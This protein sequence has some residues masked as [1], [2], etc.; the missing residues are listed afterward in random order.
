MA[1]SPT[2][3]QLEDAASSGGE[4]GVPMLGVRQD[5]DATPVSASGDW[6]PFVFDEVGRLK[7][8]TA[9]SSIVAT[10]GTVTTS[11]STVVCDV[12]RASNV[13]FYCT[14]TFAGV[15]CTFEGSLDG[16]TSWFTVQAVRS[17][18]NTIETTTGVL[19]AAPAYAWE[20]SVNGLTTFR[21]RATAWT[22]G[23]QNWRI[24][25]GSYATEPIPAAQISG[26]QPVSGTVTV[27]LPTGTTY[28]VVTTASTN[29]ASVKASA[30]SLYEMTISNPTATAAY[31]KLYNKASAP[32][33]GTD[34]PVM[35]VAIPAT[36]VGVG[37]KTFNFGAVGKRFATGIAIAVTAAAAAT[38]TASAVAGIQINATYI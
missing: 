9:P 18:A 6:H 30:G 23:T 28:N 24:Q 35:T 32:T 34:V 36:A 21:I 12:S 3:T 33:V 10:T 5:A 16:G 25:P 17:N 37:E 31:V 15:N 19:G 2:P 38:D 8:G 20:A 26:T 14:G 22:S 11:T 27:T 4:S 29:A 13:M 1:Y 7:V